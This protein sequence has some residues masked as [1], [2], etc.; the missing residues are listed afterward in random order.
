MGNGESFCDLFGEREREATT[1][2]RVIVNDGVRRHVNEWTDWGVRDWHKALC[3]F[4]NGRSLNGKTPCW[5]EPLP[6]CNW[7]CRGCWKSLCA[8]CQSNPSTRGNTSSCLSL[9]SR[10]YA[11]KSLSSDVSSDQSWIRPFGQVL[12][13]L[14]GED[15]R[16]LT[17]TTKSQLN[18]VLNEFVWH[19]FL[20][21]AWT[22]FMKH[23]V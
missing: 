6:N 20:H 16:T 5:Q 22:R 12:L 10:A 21:G 18:L 8:C 15:H 4:R 14:P 1:G 13:H 23:L 3:A 9:A 11:C 7:C 19:A 17:Y 2:E